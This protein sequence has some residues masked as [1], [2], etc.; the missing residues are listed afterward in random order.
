MTMLFYE[1]IISTLLSFLKSLFRRRI[2]QEC[3]FNL[4]CFT[5][6]DPL[7]VAYNKHV[8]GLY[9]LFPVFEKKVEIG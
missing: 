8:L 4:T 7:F 2:M 3:S 9:Y 5:L 1:T 6:S